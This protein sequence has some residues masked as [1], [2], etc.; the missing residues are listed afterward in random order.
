VFNNVATESIDNATHAAAAT[1]LRRYNLSGQPV[2]TPRQGTVV[3]E[4]RS[5][6]TTRKIAREK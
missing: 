3:I 1:T 2:A 6:G 5:D 4:Q